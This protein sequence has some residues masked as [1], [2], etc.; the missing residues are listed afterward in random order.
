M[1]PLR[2]SLL[3][4]LDQAPAGNGTAPV[5]LPEATPAWSAWL[6]VGA[7]AVYRQAALVTLKGLPE[8]AAAPLDERPVLQPALGAVLA[9]ALDHQDPL[10]LAEL[11]AGI[12]RH[13]VRVSSGDLPVLL[14]LKDAALQEAA[15]PLLGKTGKWLA[16]QG[17]WTW[18]LGLEL[19]DA[20]K[21]WSEGRSAERLAALE[22]FRTVDA[23]AAR[24][25]MVTSFAGDGAA[26][27]L[28]LIQALHVGLSLEDQDLLLQLI[29]SDR[30]KKVKA[31]ARE[32]L[33]ALDGP[34]REAVVAHVQAHVEIQRGAGLRGGKLTLSA[35]LPQEWPQELEWVFNDKHPHLG[36][37][38]SAWEKAVSKVP[39]GVWE[40]HGTPVE[41]LAAADPSEDLATVMGW[42]QAALS[43][44]RTPWI[45]PLY[46][47]WAERL[48]PGSKSEAA[49][50]ASKQIFALAPKL[51]LERAVDQMVRFLAQA[52]SVDP[53]M[54]LDVL[55]AL[56]LPWP[57]P[58]ARAWL[59]RISRAQQV[60]DLPR[61]LSDSLKLAAN[62]LP[63]HFLPQR[64]LLPGSSTT[65]VIA[66][67]AKV[68]ARRR[69]HT[70]LP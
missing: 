10:L 45:W 42:T 55:R 14:K 26:E 41:L 36:K 67:A 64:P 9:L 25:R 52:E 34:L 11:S 28:V 8:P 69:I 54:A 68:T 38:A 50:Q 27:R 3:L 18:A 65:R 44:E 37:L 1:D 53:E 29:E 63:P 48:R 70:Y 59:G 35:E 13:G 43:Q 31:A 2:K 46:Q 56:P 6:Q 47:W 39:L 19:G 5:S 21:D 62:A 24:E 30:S 49:R 32:L 51:P 23:G 40:I 58:V 12:Q 57:E 7:D 33:L 61:W 66:F 15:R 17:G 20:E 4:G 60:R 16:K 22:H